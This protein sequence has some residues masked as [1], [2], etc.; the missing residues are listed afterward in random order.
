MRE[1]FKELT[2]SMQLLKPVCR[3]TAKARPEDVLVGAR[4]HTDRI[5]LQ[6]V[7]LA[8]GSQKIFLASFIARWSVQAKARQHHLL[9]L[10]FG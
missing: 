9:S 1:I 2:F 5:N 6:I 8:N 10:L 4:Y 3:I 7:D